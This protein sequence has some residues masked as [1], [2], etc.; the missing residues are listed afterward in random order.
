[1]SLI[2]MSI[3]FYAYHILIYFS[4]ISLALNTISQSISLT[5]D[6]NTLVSKGGIYELGFFTPGNSN[7][8]YLGIWYKNIPIQTVVWVANR[9][10]PINDSSGT[11]TLNNITGNL[12]LTQKNN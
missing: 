8:R 5:D 3:I 11:L 7:K 2:I 1:M 6:G 10:N 12:V 4:Q 9:I